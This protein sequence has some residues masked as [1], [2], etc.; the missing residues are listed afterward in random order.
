MLAIGRA[1]MARP[2]LIRFDEPSLGL[3]PT[4]VEGVFDIILGIQRD[5]TT[6]FMVEQ[7][8]YIA[9]QLATRAYVIEAG[10]ITL[11]GTAREL[12]DNE[13]VRQAY[14]GG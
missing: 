4:T 8:A 3:A 10:R 7:D 14:L 5:G 9:L 12:L 11:E 1:L 13:R 6:V 2:R